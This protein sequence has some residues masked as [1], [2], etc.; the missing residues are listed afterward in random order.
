MWKMH[1]QWWKLQKNDGK[2]WE[3]IQKKS[4]SLLNPL[5]PYEE[6]TEGVFLHENLIFLWSQNHIIMVMAPALLH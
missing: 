2:M 5:Q 1:F 3:V 4:T 6:A